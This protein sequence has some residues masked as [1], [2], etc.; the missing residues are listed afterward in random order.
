[1]DQPK[2]QLETDS[3]P[4][5]S[6]EP[7]TTEEQISPY[8]CFASKQWWRNVLFMS[9]TFARQCITP[10]CLWLASLATIILP[11]LFVATTF[12]KTV[13][14]S[15]LLQAMAVYIV[16]LFIAVP[17]LFWCFGAWLVRLTAYSAALETFSRRELLLERL[18]KSRVVRVQQQ[19]LEHVRTQKLFLA[20]FWSTLT[21]F[22][23]GPCGLFF[24]SMLVLACTS[25]AVLGNSAL[26]LSAGVT[27][28][29]QAICLISG[30]VTTTVSFVGISVSAV[31]DIEPV[32]QARRTV[33]I[34]A[35]CL[36]PLS[37]ITVLSVC[38]SVLITSPDEILQGNAI[39]A[40]FVN[41]G[42]MSVVQEIWR[43]VSSTVVWTLTLAPICEFMRGRQI[44]ND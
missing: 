15:Q 1:M 43:A 7:L 26:R 40:G 25:P 33:F 20:K 38:V 14:I 10:A 8:K 4:P 23:L 36:I 44:L 35:K 19:A 28:A 16:T 42:W 2:Q 6:S 3:S 29:A 39:S 37:V 9:L 12:G 27:L 11:S 13:E 30:L 31:S 34:S 21:I 5:L 18:D 32:K 24:L 17:L 22:L 41:A